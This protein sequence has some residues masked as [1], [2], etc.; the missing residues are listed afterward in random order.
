MFSIISQLVSRKARG[1]GDEKALRS[2]TKLSIWKKRA[3]EV[4]ELEESIGEDPR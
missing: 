1:S 4:E 3:W 2:G